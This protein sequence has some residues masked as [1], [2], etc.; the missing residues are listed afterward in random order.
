MV[1]L[2]PIPLCGQS[3]ILFR[4]AFISGFVLFFLS[5]EVLVSVS[6]ESVSVLLSEV[7]GRDSLIMFSCIPYGYRYLEVLSAQ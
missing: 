5:L 4:V 7:I 1:K 3:S 2:R 6:R